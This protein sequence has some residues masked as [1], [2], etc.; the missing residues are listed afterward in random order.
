MSEPVHYPLMTAVI[1]C[2][3]DNG[4][5][6]VLSTGKTAKDAYRVPHDQRPARA[7]SPPALTH[8]S[9]VTGGLAVFTVPGHRLLGLEI[10]A[11]KGAVG[12]VLS[13]SFDRGPSPAAALNP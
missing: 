9:P 8:R 11:A 12:A 2:S 10:G 4:A 6:L 1:S 5:T 3:T 7:E 13:E